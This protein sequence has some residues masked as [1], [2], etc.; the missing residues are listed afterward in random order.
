MGFLGA[1][2]PDV[3]FQLEGAR[4]MG[5]RYL[6]YSITQPTDQQIVEKQESVLMSSKGITDAMKPMYKEYFNG[7]R[8]F[9]AENGIPDLS[10]T[11]D[12]I[13]RIHRAAIFCV[14]GKASI[15]LD[16]KSGKPDT[17]PNK[18]GVGRDRK[19]FNTLLHALQIMHAYETGDKA[20]VV[21]NAHVK[22]VE[23]CA[24]SSINRERRKCLEILASSETSLSSS[25]IGLTDGFGLGKEAVEKVIYPLFSVGLVQ[26]EKVGSA[27][28]W[29]IQDEM[30]RNFI[31]AVADVLPDE[32]ADEDSEVE[33]SDPFDN[34]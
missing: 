6:Y 34:W 33:V 10:M 13:A 11:P 26:R 12:Q 28:R 27:Y 29:K 19:M 30:I 32:I 4:S 31:R 14:L 15:H 17:I 3:Y 20:A 24:Y 5:E 23:K 18:P 7:L 9:I 8:D 16:F 21:Q 25:V 22:L 1:C 2:T